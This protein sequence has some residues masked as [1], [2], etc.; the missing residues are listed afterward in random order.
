MIQVVDDSFMKRAESNAIQRVVDHP[1]RGLMY[2]RNGKLLVFNNPI[3]DVMVVPKE[4]KVGDTTRFCELFKIS[5]EQLI[6]SYTAARKYSSVK[7][8]TFIKQISTKDFARIQD[9][10]MDYPGLFIMIDLYGPIQTPRQV[11]PWGTS[12]KSVPA[13]LSEIPWDTT[14]KVTMW[15]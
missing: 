10:L 1:Y 2:D 13:N 7:P 11:M 4:F 12:V 6:G 15:D 5:K 14:L 9:F 3:F 8:S